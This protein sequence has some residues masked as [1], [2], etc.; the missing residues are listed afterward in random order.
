MRLLTPR[1]INEISQHDIKHVHRKAEEIYQEISPDLPQHGDYHFISAVDH[2]GDRLSDKFRKLHPD[3]D[4][5]KIA[6]KAVSKYSS[7][8]TDE[9][10]EN[11]R[12]GA[13]KRLT[14]QRQQY[15]KNN[16]QARSDR[17]KKSAASRVQNLIK[18]KKE[19]RKADLDKME[20]AVGPQKLRESKSKP[21]ELYMDDEDYKQFKSHPATRLYDHRRRPSGTVKIHTSNPHKLARDLEKAIDFGATTAREVL[22]IDH[23]HE[24]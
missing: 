20:L 7:D 3:A 15:W 2:I 1:L 5:Q 13:R 11:E 4:F 17:A 24:K 19:A 18:K 16:P 21:Y 10:N 23:I 14:A 8:D 22:G 6:H 12:E 9:S